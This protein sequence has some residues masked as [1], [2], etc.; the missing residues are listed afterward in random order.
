[1]Y[2][3]KTEEAFRGPLFRV[4][5]EHWANP[6]RRRDLVRHPGAAAVLP[7]TAEG[8]VVLVRQVRE[9]LR[10]VL[11]EIPAGLYDVPGE[12]PEETARREVEEETGYRVV[13]IEILGR[14]HTSPGF[15][16]EAIDLFR[17][18]VEPAG[19]PEHGVEV[20]EMLPEEAL[21]ALGEEI[22]DAK[23][24]VALLLHARGGPPPVG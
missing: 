4:E 14:I 10:E 7:L 19:K 5:I 18:E 1:M 16:D 22:T 8:R 11:L 21:A 20:V 12:D 2:P 23:T 24:A 6:E 17:A 9:A 13:G 15:T 3:T